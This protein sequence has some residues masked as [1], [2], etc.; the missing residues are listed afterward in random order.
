[1]KPMTLVT[2]PLSHFC[3][4]ARWALDLAQL[5]YREEG[6]LP[7]FHMLGTRPRG[8]R[9][10]PLLVT[11]EGT[12]R[13][14]T[15]ILG[16]ID[17][18]YPLYPRDATQRRAALDLEDRFD[19]DLGPHV[20]RVGY[21]HMLPHKALALRTVTPGA[22]RWQR[23]VVGPL[24]PV[25][26][27]VMAK[28]LRITPDGA[29]RSLAKVRAEVAAVSELLADG[30]PYLVGD[31]FSAADLTFAALM[32]P[33]VFPP[34][35]PVPWPREAERPQ[36]LRDLA[37]ELGETLAGQHALRMYRDHRGPTKPLA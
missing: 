17:Q 27:Q 4:K 8:G 3:E 18:T 5:P 12:L 13:D 2:I 1:M 11:S 36:A 9:S 7:L 33:A 29:A 14:S 25:V 16:W 20:R 21:F 37:R 34:G 32:A 26:K 10:T 19:E 35:H 30:R 23:A 28:A 22:P 31:A 24:Y 6:H 15:D